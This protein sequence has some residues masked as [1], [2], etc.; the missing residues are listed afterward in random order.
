MLIIGEIISLGLCHD[1]V[2]SFQIHYKNIYCTYL[3]LNTYIYILDII[4]K[5][6]KNNKQIQFLSSETWSTV[7]VP[8]FTSQN[9]YN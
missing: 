3:F 9:K 5:D 7:E 1:F 6:C 8:H 4:G 2:S